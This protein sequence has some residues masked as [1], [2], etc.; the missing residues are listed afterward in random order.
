MSRFLVVAFATDHCSGCSCCSAS[1]GAVLSVQQGV[2]PHRYTL[3][4]FYGSISMF[5]AFKS[6][7]YEGCIFYFGDGWHS[8]QRRC[9]ASQC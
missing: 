2:V 1:G 8:L 6:L 9:V 4:R 5:V 7:W 3:T